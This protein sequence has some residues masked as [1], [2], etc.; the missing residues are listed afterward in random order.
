MYQLGIE[1]I[2]VGVLVVIFGFFSKH[3]LSYFLNKIINLDKY[4]YIL[5]FAAGVLVHLFCEFTGINTWYLTNSYAASQI[6]K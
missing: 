6:S 2:C 3:I 4:H 5:I 1:A